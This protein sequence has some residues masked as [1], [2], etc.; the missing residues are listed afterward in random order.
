MADPPGVAVA[1][2]AAGRGSRFG[3]DKLDAICAGKPVACWVLDAIAEAGLPPGLLVLPP[4]PVAFARSA[5]GWQQRVNPLA[6]Q[7]LGTSLAVA[8]GWA[9]ESGAAGLLVL[10]GDMPLMAPGHL[11]HLAA[12]SPPAA[13]TYPD[14]RAGVPALL[15]RELLEEAVTL[16]GD[17]GAVR[18]LVGLDGLTLIAPPAGMLLDV[19]RPEDRVMAEERLL[20]LEPSQARPS[21]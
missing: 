1:V 14:G 7:G 16:K 18:L 2:L 21:L 13:T 6:D 15:S 3:G 10:L 8:A 4:R 20:A 17:E 5:E 11:R 12:A 19:D 9:L